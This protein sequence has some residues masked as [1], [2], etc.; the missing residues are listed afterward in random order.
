MV[1]GYTKTTRMEWNGDGILRIH[2]LEGA[3]IGLEEAR[4]NQD[5]AQKLTAGRNHLALVFDSETFTVTPEARAFAAASN[6]SN[7]RI[8]MAYVTTSLANRLLGNFYIQFN[9]P[10]VPTRIFNSEISA[11]E[12]LLSFTPGLRSISKKEILDE[13]ESGE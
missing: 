10:I 6:H 9:K 8:A 13:E 1:N 12:W 5:L 4:E 11:H 7:R 3:E 2:L